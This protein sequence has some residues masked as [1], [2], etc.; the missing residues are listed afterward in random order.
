M[1]NKLGAYYTF[2]L[3][4]WAVCAYCL[5]TVSRYGNSPPPHVEVKDEEEGGEKKAKKR[6]SFQQR[7]S[8]AA[9]QSASAVRRHIC[10]HIIYVC[11]F[12]S[13]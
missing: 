11:V 13:Q 6:G 4:S 10:T 5:V 2:V 9:R 3:L 7:A 12:L 8:I 1:K